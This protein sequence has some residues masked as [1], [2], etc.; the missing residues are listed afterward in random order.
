MWKREYG[1]GIYFEKPKSQKHL[2]SYLRRKK[3]LTKIASVVRSE[4][5]SSRFHAIFIPHGQNLG[6]EVVVAV[7]RYTIVGATRRDTT[8]R[9]QATVHRPQP[10]VQCMQFL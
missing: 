4:I 9:D 7:I 2:R 5:A 8:N 10:N 3:V 6:M 1:R